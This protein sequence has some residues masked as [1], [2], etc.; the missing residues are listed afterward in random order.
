MKANRK[1]KEI[2]AAAP[3]SRIDPEVDKALNEYIKSVI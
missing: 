3:Q 1:Y 2:L